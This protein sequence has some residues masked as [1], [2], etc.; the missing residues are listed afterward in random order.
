MQAGQAQPATDALF[1]PVGTPVEAEV[2]ALVRRALE[3]GR[4]RIALQ[5][6]RATG[7]GRTMFHEA[8]LRLT[9]GS[10]VVLS[11]AQFMPWV[12]DGP[13]G[14]QLDIAALRLGLSW[15]ERN[16]G[17]RLSINL[18]GRSLSDAA[19][20]HT[21]EDW[22]ARTPEDGV[23]LILEMTEASAMRDPDATR[24]FMT[25]M[26]PRG[27]CFALDDFGAGTMAPSE[28]GEFLFDMVKIDRRFAAGIDRMANRRAAV[29][30]L[31]AVAR[32]LDLTVIAQ[33]VE[34]PAEAE[35]FAAL[36]VDGLQGYLIG[37][38]DLGA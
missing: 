15:L 22:L 30:D 12:E 14:R 28:V 6:V 3:H 17:H 36:G 19:W 10:G 20:R 38:P 21:L 33:G 23:R 7:G 27:P 9:D 35:I 32:D 25:R 29:R 37:R 16:P 5:P 26:Q 24:T 2:P 1:D 4:A 31:V 34:Y 13:L 11:A 18:S 8:L